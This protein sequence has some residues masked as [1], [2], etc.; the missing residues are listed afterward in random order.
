MSRPGWRSALALCLACL[1][2]SA[3]SAADGERPE[4]IVAVGDIHGAFDQ[5][6]TILQAAELIDEQRQWIGGRTVL[7]QTGDFLDR[8]RHVRQVMDLLRELQEQAPLVGGQVIVLLGNHEA[9]NLTGTVRDVNLEIYADFVD[10]RSPKRRKAAF[11]KVFR[12]LRERA[13]RYGFPE[14]ENRDQIETT[15][16]ES[17]PEGY[18]EYQEALAPRGLYGSWLRTLPTATLVADIL[19]IHGGIHPEL[20]TATVEEISGRVAAD[21]QAYDD[22]RSFLENKGLAPWFFTATEQF[23]AAGL[24]LAWLEAVIEARAQQTNVA[25]PTPA[26]R[27]RMERLRSMLEFAGGYLFDPDGPVWF[28][29]FAE[30]TDEEGDALVDALLTAQGTNH[31]VAAHTP[32]DHGEITVRFGGRVFLIDTGMLTE[33]YKGGKPSALEIQNGRFTAIYPES[34]ERLLDGQ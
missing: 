30:W 22:Y 12:L 17:H 1:L 10:D 15:W 2:T 8:G 4:R 25:T 28:R 13:A 14:P 32:Q 33:V 23:R 29:G 5:L 20:A 31:I 19:F 27:E 21:I 6:V 3:L 18:I 16:L 24:E 7:V 11:K 34:R 26:E 9:M